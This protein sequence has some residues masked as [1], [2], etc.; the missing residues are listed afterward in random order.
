MTRL[1]P[2]ELLVLSLDGNDKIRPL[3]P[4]DTALERLT[5]KTGQNFGYDRQAW[6]DWLDDNITH[7]RFATRPKKKQDSE[8]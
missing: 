6:E 1:S 5:H 3:L 4:R 8:E 2:Y 7:W